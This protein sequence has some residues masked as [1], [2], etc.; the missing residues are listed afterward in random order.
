MLHR[1]QAIAIIPDPKGELAAYVRRQ[2]AGE[3]FDQMERAFSRAAQRGDFPVD[4][5]LVP[6]TQS[7]CAALPAN[8]SV[9]SLP[10]REVT[11]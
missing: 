7:R 5:L 1:C 9:S 10:G 2:A 6:L 8:S 3:A 4:H 11:G